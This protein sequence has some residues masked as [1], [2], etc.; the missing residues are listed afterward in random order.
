MPLIHLQGIYFS[1]LEDF[2]PDPEILKPL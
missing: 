1:P 2:L